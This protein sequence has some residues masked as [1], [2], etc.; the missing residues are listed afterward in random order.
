MLTA[1]GIPGL[2]NTYP[3]ADANAMCD[4]FAIFVKA[5]VKAGPNLTR[6]G[7]AQALQGLGRF[8]GAYSP[9]SVFAPGKTNGGELVHAMVWR[10]DCTCYRQ[11][12][13][14]HVGKG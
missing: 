4:Y 2:A 5:A 14:L 7:W 13:P 10:A 6:P 3:N 1:R 9:Q 8:D 12:G 11:T